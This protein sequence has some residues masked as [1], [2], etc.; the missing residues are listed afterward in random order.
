MKQSQFGLSRI[1]VWAVSIF[2]V[3][4]GI[5]ILDWAGSLDKILNRV[6]ALFTREVKQEQRRQEELQRFTLQEQRCAA[7]YVWHTVTG[8]NDYK[9]AGKKAEWLAFV[10][11]WNAVK[12]GRPACKVLEDAD[13]LVPERTDRYKPMLVY[14]SQTKLAS[15]AGK[16]RQE[17]ERM[18]NT[19]GPL[20]GVESLDEV[21]PEDLKPFACVNKV[22]RSQGGLFTT[23][24]MMSLDAL[25]AAMERAGHKLV[26]T[27]P[28]PT[29]DGKPY[30][31]YC[32]GV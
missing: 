20:L 14:Y 9:Y 7:Y 32:P 23:R 28:S 11:F 3:C 4:A 17:F 18:L 24:L 6:P 29:P 12:A 15:E 13:P 1:F 10:S 30:R 16:D 31:F 2:L 22:V 5:A 19:Y 25:A 8:S 27:V 26:T 21:L